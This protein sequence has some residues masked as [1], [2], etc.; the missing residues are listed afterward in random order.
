MDYKIMLVIIS[1]IHYNAVFEMPRLKHKHNDI[2]YN[3]FRTCGI[4]E[5]IYMLI[6]KSTVLKFVD[7]ECL[8]TYN[9]INLGCT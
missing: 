2:S 4:C 1:R 6:F 8:K 9:I 3:Y 7:I 5:L